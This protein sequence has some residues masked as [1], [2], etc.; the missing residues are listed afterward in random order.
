MFEIAVTPPIPKGIKGAPDVAANPGG[1]AATGAAETSPFAAFQTVLA[2]QIGGAPVAAPVQSAGVVDPT[3]DV[4]ATLPV[5]GLPEGGKALPVTVAGLAALP[6]V[7]GDDAVKA[8]EADV[9]VPVTVPVTVRPV[10]LRSIVPA[11]TARTVAKAADEADKPAETSDERESAASPDAPVTGFVGAMPVTILPLAEATVPVVPQDALLP[12]RGAAVQPAL[13]QAAVNPPTPTA[14]VAAAPPVA[15]AVLSTMFERQDRQAPAAVTVSPAPVAREPASTAQA[16]RAARVGTSAEDISVA[17]RPVHA[18]KAVLSQDAALPDDDTAVATATAVFVRADALPAP[19]DPKA[20]QAVARPERIDFATLVDSIARARDDG[21]TVSVAVAHAEFGKVSLR[22]E[23]GDNGL[24]VAMSSA[25][26]GF[27]RAVAASGQADGG[28]FNADSQQQ[29]QQQQ[30]SASG[31]GAGQ[32]ALTGDGSHQSRGNGSARQDG[33][34]P[35]DHRAAATAAQS[36]E[37]PR[38]GIFA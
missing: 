24:S 18:V 19:Q 32:S 14:P 10:L 15:P 11:A 33:A 17:A 28:T 16:L 22:F 29:T 23:N 8:G 9:P 36:D 2:Q 34:I 13:A 26:P 6:V 1:N 5:A 4:A 38:D 12:A 37:N 27:A 21:A 7:L 3:A 31:N 25:D 30:R 20:P 35:A